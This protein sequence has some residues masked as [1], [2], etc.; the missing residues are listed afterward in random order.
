MSES[1]GPQYPVIPCYRFDSSISKPTDKLDQKKFTIPKKK[2]A[3]GL[4]HLHERVGEAE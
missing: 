4:E 3:E 2:I 1:G